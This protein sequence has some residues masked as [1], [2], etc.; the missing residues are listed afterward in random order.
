MKG[1]RQVGKKKYKGIKAVEDTL[2]LLASNGINPKFA[3]KFLGFPIKTRD[4]KFHVEFS[5][6]TTKEISGINSR[7][8]ELL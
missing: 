7:L 3:C 8:L 1:F 4:G 2:N 6:Y 5:K